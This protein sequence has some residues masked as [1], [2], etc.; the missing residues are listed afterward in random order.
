[1]CEIAVNGYASFRVSDVEIKREGLS[2]SS[3]TIAYFKNIHP[4]DE[5]YFIMGADMFLTLEKWHNFEYIFKNVTILTAPR[6]G[7]DYD[8]LCDV[9]DKYQ[10]YSCKAYITKEYIEDLSSTMLRNMIREKEDVSEYI[11][12]DVLAYINRNELYR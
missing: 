7:Y 1:M 4:D 11:D 9:Y 8:D 2:Y 10:K 3:D 12:D 6:D 5:L